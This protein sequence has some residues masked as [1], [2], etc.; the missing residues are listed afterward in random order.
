MSIQ[1]SLHGK[2]LSVAS[3]LLLPLVGTLY[4][5]FSYEGD[6]IQFVDA[7]VAGVE[8]ITPLLKSLFLVPLLGDHPAL[9]EQL[10][11]NV[12][13]YEQS[14][15]RNRS[16]L[17]IDQAD[18]KTGGPTTQE[19]AGLGDKAKALLDPN[20]SRDDADAF[21]RQSLQQLAFLVD[22]SNLSLDPD[23][24]SYYLISGL[25]VDLPSIL[26]ILN[27]AR[28]LSDQYS[29][30]LD[31][32]AK[33]NLFSTVKILEGLASTWVSHI[34]KS[35]SP[36]NAAQK[37]SRKPLADKS[38]GLDD[39]LRGVVDV[40]LEGIRRSQ[41]DTAA[42]QSKI[43]QAIE[44]M[45][46]SCQRGTPLLGA[47]LQDRK[48][49]LMGNLMIASGIDAV[50]L[51]ISVGLFVIVVSGLR[52][53]VFAMMKGLEAAASGDLTVRVPQEGRDEVESM[54][55]TFNRFLVDLGT[56]T[57]AIQEQT[58]G[59]REVGSRLPETMQA[60]QEQLGQISQSVAHID[61]RTREQSDKVTISV[62]SIRQVEAKTRDLDE[63]IRRQ[64]A[65]ARES[66]EDVERLIQGIR[67]VATILEVFSG[68]FQQLLTATEEGKSAL[69]DA[70]EKVRSLAEQSETLVDANTTISD[71]ASKT[72]LLAMN[73]AIE[74]A[75]AGV[76]G[77]GFSVVAEE[78]RK[79]AEEADI[80]AKATARELGKIETAIRDAETSSALVE[81]S[82]DHVVDAVGRVES[83]SSD[84]RASLGSQD[85]RGR[86]VLEAVAQVSQT[87][88]HI[89]TDSNVMKQESRAAGTLAEELAVI[90]N[91]IRRSMGDIRVGVESIV[92]MTTQ[93]TGLTHQN[94]DWIDRAEAQVNRF[95]TEAGAERSGLRMTKTGQEAC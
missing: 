67:E 20:S 42:F 75:H 23:L 47:M 22:V 78:I 44:A 21:N 1:L 70:R 80:Q 31:E 3:L 13:S 37:E 36:L 8:A 90:T 95:Q 82:F 17:Q 26:G 16:L 62:D 65:S 18:G 59:L 52:R 49:S 94:A 60:T 68:N 41:L 63:Q 81:T 76:A 93:V 2:I 61:A 45:D 11:Q 29:G 74:A 24:S 58:L 89:A 56:L 12:A 28:R 83:L 39:A 88:E 5:L 38:R 57:N 6:Q 9:A 66:R 48:S 19:F 69:H 43:A 27:S 35:S 4:F 10:T 73:A 40:G 91:E 86:R 25:Y 77:H 87:A 53:R 92:T 7:E 79:L 54:A 85:E 14:L 84:V 51:L 15:G 33:L 55:A 50:G 46:Q 64:S 32:A 30:P 72:N 34:Q 71:I